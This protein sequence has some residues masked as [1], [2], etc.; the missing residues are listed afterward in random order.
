MN[1]MSFT[2]IFARWCL[3][4]AV[5]ITCVCLYFLE[6]AVLDSFWQFRPSDGF[7]LQMVVWILLMVEVIYLFVP[8]LNREVGVGKLFQANYHAP[9]KP[10]DESKMFKVV[11][12]LNQGMTRMLLVWFFFAA[13]V[14]LLFHSGVIGFRGLLIWTAVYYFTDITFVIFFCPF[15]VFIMKNSCCVNCRIYGYGPFFIFTPLVFMNNFFS[16]TLF[17]VSTLFLLVWEL[18]AAYHPERFSKTSNAALQCQNCEQKLC[19][20]KRKLKIEKHFGN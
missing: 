9:D 17:G 1:K 6:P 7:G 4:T 13:M 14:G 20:V 3:R 5:L 18:Q 16:W 10:Y 12:Q 11:K 2:I 19:R 15:Q 8:R